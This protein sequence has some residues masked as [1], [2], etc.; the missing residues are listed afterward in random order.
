MVSPKKTPMDRMWGKIDIG[1]LLL[2]QY[3]GKRDIAL[4]LLSQYGGKRDIALTT[5][6]Y[7]FIKIRENIM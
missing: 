2:S 5:H 3:G 7:H 1:L 4:L 6:D